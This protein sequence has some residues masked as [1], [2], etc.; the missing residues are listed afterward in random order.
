MYST[1]SERERDEIGKG[2]EITMKGFD[3][4]QHSF[5]FPF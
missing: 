3:G 1:N 4:F 5:P 2:K